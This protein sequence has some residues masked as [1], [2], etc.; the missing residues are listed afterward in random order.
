M[1][2]SMITSFDG[3]KLYLKKETAA[4]NKAVIVIVHGLC[5]HQGRYVY[6]AEK[7]HEAGIGTYR[8]DHRGHGRSEGEETFYSD[9]NELLDDTNVVV[10]MAIEEN[11]DIVSIGNPGARRG[12]WLNGAEIIPGK[13]RQSLQDFA[14]LADVVDCYLVVVSE[15]CSVHKK[16]PLLIIIIVSKE[17]IL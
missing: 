8:F 5:E 11:P 2:E 17:C 14:E 7:L 16:L 12:G 6:F 3:T 13:R 10:D 4:D 15:V 9:F 1:G